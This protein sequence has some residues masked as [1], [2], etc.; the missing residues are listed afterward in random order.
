MVGGK[1]INRGMGSLKKMIPKLLSGIAMSGSG[2]SGGG[3]SAGG[4]SG[5]GISGGKKSVSKLA[6]HFTD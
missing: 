2:S 3:M 5:G 4:L 1:L 6:K